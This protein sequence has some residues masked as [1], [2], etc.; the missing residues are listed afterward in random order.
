MV[1]C[2]GLG[3]GLIVRPVAHMAIR[4]GDLTT[5]CKS[6]PLPCR[7]FCTRKAVHVMAAVRGRPSGLPVTLFRFANLRT[8]ATHSFGDE[9]VV[10]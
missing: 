7:C 1:P 6:N 10:A 8:A 5:E 3:G 4:F 2:V 9:C